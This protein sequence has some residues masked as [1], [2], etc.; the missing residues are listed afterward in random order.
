MKIQ[1]FFSIGLLI[2]FLPASN[3]FAE[4]NPLD[5]AIK[6][7]EKYGD[8]T[9]LAYDKDKACEIILDCLNKC[10][11][12]PVDKSYGFNRLAKL[13][14]MWAKGDSKDMAATRQYYLN[15]IKVM[16]DRISLDLLEAKVNFTSLISDKS[17][18]IRETL[19]LCAWLAYIQLMDGETFQSS[20][21]LRNAESLTKKQKQAHK[22]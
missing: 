1:S 16:G 9:T 5:I 8:Y 21:A 14:S 18:K 2:A 22:H 6:E 7:S 3:I 12:L 13:N 15:S 10:P 4:T 17:E 11:L 19:R 20:I